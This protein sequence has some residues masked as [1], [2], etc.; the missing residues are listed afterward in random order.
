MRTLV[1]NKIVFK[2]VLRNCSNNSTKCGSYYIN[3]Y[4]I[5]VSK[6]WFTEPTSVEFVTFRK[7]PAINCQPDNG[8]VLAEDNLLGVY[9]RYRLRLVRGCDHASFESCALNT[10][11]A[12]S[13]GS[14]LW[15]CCPLTSDR[16]VWAKSN[17]ARGCTSFPISHECQRVEHMGRCGYPLSDW[18]RG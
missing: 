1:R 4:D 3:S 14:A 6:C 18:S 10:R 12:R 9:Y 11:S 8:T 16:S 17:I 13:L 15:S 5:N 2:E 7:T